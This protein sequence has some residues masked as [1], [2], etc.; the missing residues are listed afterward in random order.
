MYTGLDPLIISHKSPTS[1]IVVWVF[2][3][4]DGWASQLDGEPGHGLHVSYSRE[5]A[6]CGVC[7]RV[8]MLYG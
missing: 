4:Y 1:S 5:K 7:V 2:K 3:W 8:Y 6:A